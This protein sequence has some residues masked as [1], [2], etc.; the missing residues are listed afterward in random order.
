MQNAASVSIYSK[1]LPQCQTYEKS[2]LHLEAV[3]QIKTH[4]RKNLISTLSVDGF[5]KVWTKK[6]HLMEFCRKFKIMKGNQGSMKES[7]CGNY[8]VVMSMEENCFRILDLN[9]KEIANFLKSEGMCTNFSFIKAGNSIGFDIIFWESETHTLRRID[10]KN[11]KILDLF[12]KEKTKALLSLEYWVQGKSWVLINELFHI[13]IIET[14][15]LKLISKQINDK[16]SF[17]SKFDTDLFKLRKIIKNG[18]GLLAVKL[19]Q[20]KSLLVILTFQFKLIVVNLYSGKIVHL[21]DIKAMLADD[22]P[23]N[24]ESQQKTKEV[25]KSKDQGKTNWLPDMMPKLVLSS[26]STTQNQK[27]ELDFDKFE[28]ICILPSRVGLLYINLESES[29][30]KIIGHK[31]KS[32]HFIGASLFQGKELRREKG[33]MGKGGQSSQEKVYDPNLYCWAFEK[34]RF[35]IFSNRRP[36][37]LKDD[38]NRKRKGLSGRDEM[39][40]VI[41]KNRFRVLK[42]HEKVIKLAKK[43]MFSTSMGNIYIQLHPEVSHIIKHFK[44]KT[45]LL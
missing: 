14:S 4:S 5:L 38:G 16:V 44:A 3:K 34:N 42:K 23:S 41:Q 17:D 24:P 26:D 13:D 1:N 10:L 33:S 21:L 31:E 18:S 36:I 11:N 39:N 25:K 20:K 12:T 6:S 32:L 2:W 43:V 9:T 22:F 40:E 7:P 29:I 45:P 8:L 27:Y 37:E 19:L 15:T 30:E 35:Y 28:K